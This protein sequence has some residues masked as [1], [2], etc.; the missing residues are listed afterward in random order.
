MLVPKFKVNNVI[1]VSVNSLLY[2]QTNDLTI[3]PTKSEGRK[4]LGTTKLRNSRIQ[5]YEKYRN[6]RNSRIQRYKTNK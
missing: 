4:V 6:T 3:P 2:R 5:K 1:R